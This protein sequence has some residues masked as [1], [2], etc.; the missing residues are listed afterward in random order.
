MLLDIISEYN[1]DTKETL[2]NL[3]K[4]VVLHLAKEHDPKKILSFINKCAII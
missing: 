2:R 3:R 4:T 1:S